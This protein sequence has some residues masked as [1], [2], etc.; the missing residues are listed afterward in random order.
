MDSRWGSLFRSVVRAP[1]FLRRARLRREAEVR[2]STSFPSRAA[3]G[4]LVTEVFEKI[5]RIPGWF[6]IDDCAHFYLV[7]QMQSAYGATGD[8]LEI[9]SFFGRS[10]A[11]L[12]YCLK[13]GERLMVCDA[14]EQPTN[15]P[16][17]VRPTP[18]A[19]RHHVRSVN[20]DLADESLVIMPGY[21]SALRFPPDQRF[22][23][24]HVDG[25]HSLAEALGDLRLA[26]RHLASGGV[27]AVDDHAHPDFPEVT[28]AVRQFTAESADIHVLA[29]LNR[30][31]ALGRKLY[32]VR[33][34]G[35]NCQ[36]FWG[37][38]RSA[39]LPGCSV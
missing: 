29:D 10:T 35:A 31:G 16:Y 13:P 3:P 14:F 5:R 39:S 11:L 17:P 2:N 4:P 38:S 27:L 18:D 22:R 32:L 20:P 9:G 28:A 36:F 8:V 12:A 37:K 30:H 6:N 19:L 15:D 33:R 26:A 7:L 21:S 23:F 1:F 25:G 34:A 24:I